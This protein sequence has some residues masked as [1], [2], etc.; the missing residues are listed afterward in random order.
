MILLIDNY[1]SFVH[2]LARYIREAGQVTEVIRNDVC[3]VDDIL[4]KQ[5]DGIVLS[6]GP[7]RPETAGICCDLIRAA[8]EIPLLGVCLGHQCLAEVYGGDVVPSREPMHGRPGLIHH[9]GT[10]ILRGLPSPFSA[11]RYHSLAVRLPETASICVQAHTEDQEIMAMRHTA[12]PHHGV[13]FHPESLLTDHGR[14]IIANFLQL[15][16]GA[17]S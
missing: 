9:D 3:T 16:T 12:R 10:G 17:G 2:N 7:G 11:G 8:A 5:A 1:D 4:K 13:Q 6:P 15:E 14:V